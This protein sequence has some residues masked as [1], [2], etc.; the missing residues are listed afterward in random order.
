MVDWQRVHVFAKNTY[1]E[2]FPITSFLLA[3]VS[4]YKETIKCISIGDILFMELDNSNKY[5]SSAIV[6]K[7]N[8]SICGYV[9][10]GLKE[11]I[12]SYAPCKVKVIDKRYVENDIFSLR[13]DLL[14]N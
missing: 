5:D 7:H 4:N 14:N 2:K 11:K 6:I 3:G 10:K 13:V 1:V 12:N 8:N 9:P